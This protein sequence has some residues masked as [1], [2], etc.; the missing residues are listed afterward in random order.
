MI[1]AISRGQA[2]VVIA[3][4]EAEATAPARARRISGACAGRVTSAS[5]RGPRP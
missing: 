3:N 1:P 2:R 4:G 5:P